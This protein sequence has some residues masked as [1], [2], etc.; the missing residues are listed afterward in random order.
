MNMQQQTLMRYDPKNGISRPYP[1]HA[2]QYRKYHGK[3]AWLVNPWTGGER[4]AEDIGW[5][6][7]GLLIIPPAEEV[8]AL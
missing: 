8:S 6:T 2:E 3:V 7:F 4:T 1:S 5:D